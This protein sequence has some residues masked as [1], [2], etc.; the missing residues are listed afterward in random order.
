MVSQEQ[1]L[2]S[3]NWV[4]PVCTQPSFVSHSARFWLP[5]LLLGSG[6]DKEVVAR[7][8]LHLSTFVSVSAIVNG[9]SCV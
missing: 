2:T 5:S 9:C 7:F 6:Q 8:P 4:I 1:S 3:D